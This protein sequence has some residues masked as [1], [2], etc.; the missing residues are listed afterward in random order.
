M[1]QLVEGSREVSESAHCFS[2]AATDSRLL[3]G[4]KYPLVIA[5]IFKISCFYFLDFHVVHRFSIHF[6]ELLQFPK[7]YLKTA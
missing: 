2:A 6:S 1:V 4:V 5:V 3:R 7:A